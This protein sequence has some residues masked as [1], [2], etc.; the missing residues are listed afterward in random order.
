MVLICVILVGSCAGRQDTSP[1]EHPFRNP[2]AFTSHVRCDNCGMDRNRFARTRYVFDTEK[3]RFYTCS[4]AC[5][6]ILS[7]KMDL[8]PENIKVAEYLNPFNMIEADRAVYVIGS[9]AKGTMTRRS[10][11]AFFSKSQAERF[12]AEYGGRIATFREALQEARKEI[13]KE[14]EK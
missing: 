5:L 7:M 1:F 6:V 3:G 14:K 2:P 13:L 12:V 4:I 8:K 10:K 9:K 11:I